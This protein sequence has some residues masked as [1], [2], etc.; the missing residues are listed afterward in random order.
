MTYPITHQIREHHDVNGLWK[1]MEWALEISLN[2][3]QIHGLRQ[4]KNLAEQGVHVRIFCPKFHLGGLLEGDENIIQERMRLGKEA[5]DSPIIW[6]K[7]DLIE[8]NLD[9]DKN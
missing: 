4:I 5:L 2:T 6:D 1:S 9:G 8:V 3:A 7:N